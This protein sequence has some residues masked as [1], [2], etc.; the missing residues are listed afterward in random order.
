LGRSAYLG[1][2]YTALGLGYEF[3]PLLRGQMSLINNLG[4][5]SGLCSINAV[6]SLSNEVELALDLGLP[7]GKRPEGARIRSEF[8]LYPYSINLEVRYYF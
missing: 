7:F 4:D 1:R 5:N 8:G 6:Y 3:T 2:D